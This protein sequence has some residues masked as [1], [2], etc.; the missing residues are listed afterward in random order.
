MLFYFYY[1]ILVCLPQF[2]VELALQVGYDF[3]HHRINLLIGQ[4]FFIVLQ[5]K[6]DGV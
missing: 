6:A 2:G 5:H 4:R 1:V 3:R